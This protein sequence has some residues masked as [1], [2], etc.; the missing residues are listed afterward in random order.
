MYEMSVVQ[1]DRRGERLRGATVTTVMREYRI[2][3]EYE[4]PSDSITS[5]ENEKDTWLLL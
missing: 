1:R 5:N 3:L 2:L 4:C